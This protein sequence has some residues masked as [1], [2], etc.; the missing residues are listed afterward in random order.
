[1]LVVAVNCWVADDTNETA[2]GVRVKVIGL[3]VRPKLA[4]VVTPATLAVTV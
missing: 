4:G 3:L 1:M 2:V